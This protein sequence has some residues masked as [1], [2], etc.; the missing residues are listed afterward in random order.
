MILAHQGSREEAAAVMADAKRIFPEL[1]S[2]NAKGFIGRR[3][4]KI[5]QDAGLLD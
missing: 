5:L 3:G 1:C 4:V 2:E